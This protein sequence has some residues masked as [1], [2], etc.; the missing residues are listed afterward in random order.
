MYKSQVEQFPFS[1]CVLLFLLLHA[2]SLA[3]YHTQDGL[4]GWCVGVGQRGE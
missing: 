2:S 3:V 4:E 1:V